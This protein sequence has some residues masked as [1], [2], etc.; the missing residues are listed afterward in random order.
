MKTLLL[1][2]LFL[3]IAEASS[4][5]PDRG[6]YVCNV[7]NEESICDQILKPFFAGDKLTGISVEYVGWCGS[8]GP[9]TYPCANGVC[10]NAGLK[11]EFRDATHY[12]WENKQYGFVCEMG[13]KIIVL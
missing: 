3:T 12:R 13:K 2:F 4:L 8:M 1:S 9:Y 10:E 7:G 11:F 5:R 6:L